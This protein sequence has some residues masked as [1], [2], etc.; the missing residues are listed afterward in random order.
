[1]KKSEIKVGGLYRAKVSNN[2]VTVRVDAIRETFGAT[3]RPVLAYDVTNLS[4]GRKTTFRSAMKFR[5]EVTQKEKPTAVVPQSAIK[6]ELVEAVEGEGKVTNGYYRCTKCSYSTTSPAEMSSHERR[7]NGHNMT[8]VEREGEQSSD[9]TV[10]APSATSSST[11]TKSDAAVGG[12]GTT[13]RRTVEPKPSVANLSVTSAVVPIQ[14]AAAPQ[15]ATSGLAAKLRPQVIDNSPHVI[16]E[17]RAGTGKTTT[18]IEGLKELKGIGSQLTPSPQQR[19]VWDAIKQS[20]ASSTVCFVAFN[21]SIATEL[22]NRVPAGCEASTMHAMGYSVVRRAFGNL[23]VAG[24]KIP[25]KVNTVTAELLGQD[26]WD[27]RR[28]KPMLVNA[29]KELVELCKSNLIAPNGGGELLQLVSHYDIDMEGVDQSQVFDLV[30]RVLER[31][32]DVTKDRTIDYADMVWL[33]VVLN[34]PVVRYDILLVDEAQD[35]NRCQQELAKR[36][37]RRLILCGD[38]KQAIY[39]FAGADSESMKRMEQ[40]LSDRVEANRYG[41]DESVRGCIILP[42]TVTRRCGKAIVR[43]AN[44][45]VPDFDAF[46]TNP[47]GV[48][49]EAR[50]PTDK[51]NRERPKPHYTDRCEEGNMV[52]CR[53]NA[54]LVSQCF[55][56]LKAG[57]K[58]N[59][60]G[61]DV[62][63]GLISTVRKLAKK[64]SKSDPDNVAITSLVR[65]LSDWFHEE[66]NKEQAK[67]NPSEARLIAIEDRHDCLMC[68]TEDCQRVAD[69]VRK[70]EN[71][72]ADKQCPN[73]K[74]KYGEN[75]DVC[76]EPRCGK[77]KL[78]RPEGVRLSS[79]HK[80]KG[81]EAKRV[82]LLQPD[83]ATV[84]HPMAKTAW[85]VEQEWNLKYVAITRAIEELVF[86]S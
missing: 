25:A 54:P 76:Y 48:I 79:I 21:K 23:N 30:P 11:P 38:P 31:C 72:F 53:V 63:Q 16:V 6:R 52:L 1:V 42:L 85:Q 5:S 12:L 46:E 80:A 60:Q 59:I 78:V 68:F 57:K 32:K 15:T 47:E 50:Y 35:L 77:P 58:A 44:K 66:T 84:P 34:L 8:F 7:N 40:E 82:F 2:I 28:E 24:D 45:I 75:A 61:R 69:L 41:A 83:K 70:I 20:P 3:D 49:S 56:F 9:P 67:K 37:G 27:L 81:L 4:T 33:P 36:A 17:A 13:Q 18:L 14:T 71:V 39:G 43:E 55:R 51:D 22:K 29:V 19:A 62:G 10:S 65:R 74:K 26:L 64:D 86:V 73:C